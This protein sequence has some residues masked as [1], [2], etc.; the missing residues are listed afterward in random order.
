MS[1]V[2]E[3]L[4][5]H[6]L[7]DREEQV[8]FRREVVVDHTDAR[9]RVLGNAAQGG[10]VHTMGGKAFCGSLQDARLDVAFGSCHQASFLLTRIDATTIRMVRIPTSQTSSTATSEKV[11]PLSAIP[12]TMRMKCVS[13]SVWASH[14]AGVGMASNG[15]MKTL[16]GMFSRRKKNDI[17]MACCCDLATV[18]KTKPRARLAAMNTKANAYSSP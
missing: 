11:L 1:Q 7:D 16:S 18:E 9:A 12:R 8:I 3:Q 13:G 4:R 5:I 10:G 6:F 17:C 2:R 14:C 15:N